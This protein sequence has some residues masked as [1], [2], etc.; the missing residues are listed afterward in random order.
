MTHIGM[1]RYSGPVKKRTNL[2]PSPGPCDK[3]HHAAFV[4]FLYG[5]GENATAYRVMPGKVTLTVT[6]GTRRLPRLSTGNDGRGRGRTLHRHGGRG[7]P[8]PSPVVGAGDGRRNLLRFDRVPGTR[9]GPL[10]RGRRGTRTRTCTSRVQGV[11]TMSVRGQAEIT[12]G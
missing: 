8:F 12:T 9:R 4:H 3:R 7:V 10:H 6:N 11:N 1:W 5:L 2:N